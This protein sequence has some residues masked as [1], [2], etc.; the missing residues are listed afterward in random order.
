MLGYSALLALYPESNVAVFAVA[1][2][3]SEA[4]GPRVA[5]GSRV[6]RVVAEH[7]VDRSRPASPRPAVSRAS[8]DLTA[9]VGDYAFSVYCHTCTAD[10]FA[11]GAWRRGS[12]RPVSAADGALRVGD[13]VYLPTAE[14]DVFVRDDGDREVFFGRGDDGRVVSFTFSTSPDTFEKVEG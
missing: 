14:A 6:S 9:Y 2:R 8:V 1:N 3:H 7:L 4:G 11:R 12:L 13:E 10:E 5:L